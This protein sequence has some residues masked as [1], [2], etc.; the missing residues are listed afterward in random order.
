MGKLSCTPE[1]QL[2]LHLYSPKAKVFFFLMIYWQHLLI[3][4]VNR[5]KGSSMT[6]FPLSVF[7]MVSQNSTRVP[8]SNDLPKDC[9]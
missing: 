8:S 2:H 6:V 9:K 5:F 4:K 3:V 1:V 7:H